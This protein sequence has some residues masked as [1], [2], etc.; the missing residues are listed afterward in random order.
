MNDLCVQ[1]APELRCSRSAHSLEQ[2]PAPGIQA[3]EE[4]SAALAVASS[5]CNLVD[6]LL[7]SIEAEAAVVEKIGLAQAESEAPAAVL[8]ELR[9]QGVASSTCAYALR[10]LETTAASAVASQSGPA[11]G[12]VL[13][14]TRTASLIEVVRVLSASFAANGLRRLQLQPGRQAH[15]R[16]LRSGTPPT[17]DS[18]TEDRQ[19]HSRQQT[20]LFGGG[21]QVR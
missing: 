19:A 14:E 20:R 12:G 17:A 3:L 18:S 9:L 13:S 16:S 21:N 10:D 11:G 7:T 15:S 6:A 8:L 2:R 4:N 1:E 5:Y